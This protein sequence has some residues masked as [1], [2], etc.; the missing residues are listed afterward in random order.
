MKFESCEGRMRS[1]RVPGVVQSLAHELPLGVVLDLEQSLPLGGILDLG[2][3]PCPDES[4]STAAQTTN[5][6]R[7]KRTKDRH[8]EQSVDTRNEN[9]GMKHLSFTATLRSQTGFFESSYRYTS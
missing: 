2:R 4:V 7:R 8:K 9:A 6:F 1:S 3:A 5:T